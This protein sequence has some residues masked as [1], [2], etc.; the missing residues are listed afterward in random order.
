MPEDRGVFGCRMALEEQI[1][2]LSPAVGDRGQLSLGRRED[3][4]S[5]AEPGSS[6]WLLEGHR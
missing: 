1:P 3:G 6:A 2:E 4:G 5:C